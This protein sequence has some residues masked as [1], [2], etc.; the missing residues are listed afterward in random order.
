MAKNTTAI[1]ST[2]DGVTVVHPDNIGKGIKWNDTTK[3]YEVDVKEDSGIIINELG[4]L[5]V[6]VSELEDNALRVIDGKL[7]SGTRARPELTALYV[8]AVN[9]VD[10]DPLKVA[11]A[12]TKAMPLKTFAYANSVAEYNTTR[13]IFLKEN[14][15]HIVDASTVFKVKPGILQINAYGPMFD[16]YIGV[17][18]HPGQRLSRDGQTA[19]LVFTGS[20]PKDLEI[21]KRSYQ[22]LTCILVESASISTDGIDIVNDLNFTIRDG[23]YP[24]MHV[25][26]NRIKLLNGSTWYHTRGKISSRG[27]TSE[28][29]A[30]GATVMLSNGLNSCGIF[31]I[32]NSSLTV[33][34]LVNKDTFAQD[35]KCALV[36][37]SG[38]NTRYNGGTVFNVGPDN[39]VPFSEVAKRFV[40]KQ[41][42]DLGNG[43]YKLLVP[44]SN[45]PTAYWK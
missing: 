9:G 2:I 41:L 7:Y 24:V 13:T 29:T 35:M 39:L 37:P 3:K 12:G 40:G 18:A 17:E 33:Y 27:T 19:R 16:S 25:E 23:K 8:D 42:E 21:E 38:W 6:R 22:D 14:Q 30:S 11:G 31:Y 5:E 4:E 36:G 45:I 34:S 26:L 15:D 43:V 10:Q 44:V 32:M 20:V 1:G 28:Q